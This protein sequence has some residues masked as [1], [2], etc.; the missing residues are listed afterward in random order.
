MARLLRALTAATLIAT[1]SGLLSLAA[2]AT[3]DHDA[4]CFACD[5]GCPG[6]CDPLRGPPGPLCCCAP[7]VLV[8]PQIALTIIDPVV[9]SIPTFHIDTKI[10]PSITSDRIFH[11]PRPS[12]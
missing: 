11:P 6:S 10:P 7:Q 8:A 3:H 4:E 5:T 12:V 9:S 1:C 2:A